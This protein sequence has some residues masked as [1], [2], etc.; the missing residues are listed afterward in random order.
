MKLQAWSGEPVVVEFHTLGAGQNKTLP[1]THEVR[2]MRRYP[3]NSTMGPLLYVIG[4]QCPRVVRADH[5]VTVWH[6]PEC[7]EIDRDV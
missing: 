3:P 2:V 4:C 1:S 7:P 5:W 6:S